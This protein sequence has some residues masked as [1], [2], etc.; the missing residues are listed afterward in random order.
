M[1]Q[2]MN[3]QRIEKFVN[4]MRLYI[5]CEKSGGLHLAEPGL[6]AGWLAD[7]IWPRLEI[8]KASCRSKNSIFRFV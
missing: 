4:W 1:A 7:E 5:T 8:L 2:W 3:L 6:T